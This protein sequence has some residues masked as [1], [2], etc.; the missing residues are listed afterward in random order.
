MRL[1]RRCICCAVVTAF[2]ASNAYTYKVSHDWTLQDVCGD[3]DYY[4]NADRELIK[5][6][7]CEGV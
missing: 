3:L 2:I 7:L 4:N 1:I 5:I 6:K